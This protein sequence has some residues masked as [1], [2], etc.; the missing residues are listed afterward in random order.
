[1]V[2]KTLGLESSDK[3]TSCHYPEH[4]MTHFIE[5]IRHVNYSSINYIRGLDLA[6]A[7]HD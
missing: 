7:K 4:G 5:A 6:F 3:C 2:M 1:M